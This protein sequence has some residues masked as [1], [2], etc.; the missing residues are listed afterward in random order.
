MLHRKAGSTTRG[1]GPT[2]EFTG[3][4]KK[5]AMVTSLPGLEE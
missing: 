5:W 3:L 1:A 2:A 4:P